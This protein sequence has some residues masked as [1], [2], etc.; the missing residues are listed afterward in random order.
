ML[1]N[2]GRIKLHLPRPEDLHKRFRIFLQGRLVSSSLTLV[3]TAFLLEGTKISLSDSIPKILHE[4]RLYFCI[5][6]FLE[7]QQNELNHYPSACYLYFSASLLGWWS[8]PLNDEV[9][10]IIYHFWAELCIADNL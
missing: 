2:E 9:S 7:A 3:F 4:Y 10:F 8:L 6:P 1:R 5:M